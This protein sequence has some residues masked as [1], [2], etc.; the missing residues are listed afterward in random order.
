M[1]PGITSLASLSRTL[2]YPRT[3]HAS[4]LLPTRSTLYN[5][6]QGFQLS[7][8]HFSISQRLGVTLPKPTERET[9]YE[10]SN[11]RPAIELDHNVTQEET[12]DYER[13]LSE[14][15]NKQIRTPWQREGSD[16]PP[17]ARQRSAGA[18]TKGSL[19]LG[20]SLNARG[21]Q[22]IMCRVWS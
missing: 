17:V 18:M 1:K 5:R 16:V 11:A 6:S 7:L 9:S 15:K 8:R 4:N 12:D 22:A 21:V 3:P 13:K 14:Q 10:S 20:S 19:P 2:A